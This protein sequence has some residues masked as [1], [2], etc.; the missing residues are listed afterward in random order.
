MACI[1]VIIDVMD[2]YALVSI[3]TIAMFVVEGTKL[4]PEM[5]ISFVIYEFVFFTNCIL[6]VVRLYVINIAKT[7]L[8][9]S[10]LNQ[11]LS[12][13][14]RLPIGREQSVITQDMFS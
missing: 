10:N 6:T 13:H 3:T 5:L 2:I 12:S 14:V 7:F 4:F 11:L 9:R 8:K 1:I